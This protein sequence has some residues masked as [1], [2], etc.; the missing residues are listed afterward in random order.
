MNLLRKILLYMPIIVALFAG[1]DYSDALEEGDKDIL[2]QIRPFIK[3]DTV[4]RTMLIYIMAENSISY[5]LSRDF[6]E[7]KDGAYAL[8]DDARLF[9]YFDNSD[10][11]RMPA[12]YQYHPYNDSLIE[13]VVYSFDED[14]CSSDTAV[15][16]QVLDVI[17]DNYPTESFDLI[18]GSHANGWI[19][20]QA[21]SA[22]HRTIGIDNGENTYTNT[23]T[24]TIEIEELAT[25]LDRLPVKVDRLM[26]D[27]CLMQGVEVA[28]ALR[29]AADWIIASPAEIPADGAPYDKII[30][31]FFDASSDVEDIM[32][33]YKKA[34]DNEYY[35]VVLSA[36]RTSYLQEFADST[37]RYVEKYFD[38]ASPRNLYN[39]KS[40]VPGN[41]PAYYDMNS[42]MKS[43]HDVA[44]YESWR[45]VYDKAVPYVMVSNSKMVY[46]AIAGG[47]IVNVSNDCGAVSAYFPQDRAANRR[48][49]EDF[50]T[51]EW[52]KAA[53]WDVAGW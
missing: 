34:Y 53:G 20:H 17:F 4:S 10:A 49:N 44:D 19:R 40:Y 37:R 1:C 41:I 30:S 48:H 33:E 51:T 36:I 31:L 12:L 47:Y 42:V 28:Y 22:P 13:N 5:D 23:I 25:L 46:S 11:E 15:M 7:I 6:S 52:Y 24:T 43:V 32:Y 21:K 50:K 14:V 3:G 8:P 27:A 29:N 38:I 2:P 9:V 45:T 39:C 35:G 18:M 26:F 16:R